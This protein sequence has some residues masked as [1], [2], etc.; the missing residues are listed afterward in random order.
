MFSSIISLATRCRVLVPTVFSFNNYTVFLGI[1]SRPFYIHTCDY[2]EKGSTGLIH[3]Q[4]EKCADTCKM[5]H[6]GPRPLVICGPSGSGKSTLLQ[7]LFAEFPHKF[8][9]SVSHTTRSPRPGEVDGKHYHFTTKEA[10]T[11]AIARGE[12]IESAEFSQNI[13]GTSKA[14][15]HA[16]LSEGKVCVLDIDM[17]GVKKVKQLD[18]NPLYIFIMPP[19]VEELESRLRERG[20]ETAE[21]LQRRLDA[22]REEIEYGNT[23]DNFD[24][25]VVNHSLDKAYASLREFVVRELGNDKVDG[26]CSD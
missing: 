6:H 20:T 21:S 19:S 5:V 18:M 24:L 4:R 9:F 15:V 10:M 3:K 7:R 22:A 8:G 11:E 13:Y 23:P 2:C 17:Q 16:V 25:V 26:G 14:A 12:F 1:L